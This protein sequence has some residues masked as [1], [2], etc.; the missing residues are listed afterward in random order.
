MGISNLLVKEGGH[1]PQTLPGLL[2]RKGQRVKR[3]SESKR[4]IQAVTVGSVLT[5]AQPLPEK[6]VLLGLCAD[7][8]PFLMAME[9]P[10]VGAVLVSGGRGS[11]KTHQLQVMVEAAL[12]TSRPHE[13][14]ITVISHNPS[15]WQVSFKGR[16]VERFL[17]GIFAWYDPEVEEHIQRLTEM[18]EGRRSGEL[19]GP[20]NLVIL[21]DFHF[22]ETLNPEA[23]VNCRWLLEYGSQS[24]VWMVAAVNAFQSKSLPFWVDVFR[25]RLFGWMPSRL[26]IDLQGQPSGLRAED[27]EPGTFRAWTGGSWITYQLPLLG[28]AL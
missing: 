6:S 11:G 21:D 9:E 22:V 2:S 8:L 17:Q 25:T 4:P 14:Q 20:A 23:Q 24:R 13:L 26:Q 10:E 18:A 5:G 15:E 1:F 19:D 16:R 28:D 3:S 12:R 27:L 7:G